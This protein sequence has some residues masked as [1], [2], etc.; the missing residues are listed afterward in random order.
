MRNIN[1]I[2]HSLL[3]AVAMLTVSFSAFAYE[4]HVV[5]GKGSE[6]K[7]MDNGNYELAIKRLER[8]IAEDSRFID[9]RLTN[10]C[11]AYVATG[12]LENASDACDRAVDADGDYVGTAFNSRGVLR[13]LQGD[14]LAAMDD[15]EQARQKSNYP[16]P[17]PNWGDQFPSMRRYA[18]GTNA[19]NSIEL[20]ARNFEAADRTWAAVRQEAESLTAE[21]KK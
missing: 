3:A 16:M 7:A 1:R 8:R 10:L 12:Q 4:V 20:A 17:R 6:S 11:T 15:F 2:F 18:D 21:A 19:D 9:V 5:E 13:A 14:Y